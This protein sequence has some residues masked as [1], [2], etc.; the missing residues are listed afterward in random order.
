MESRLFINPVAI[1]SGL[2]PDLQ[3][4]IL[5]FLR[6]REAMGLTR[7]TKGSAGF[8]QSNALWAHFYRQD[9]GPLLCDLEPENQTVKPVLDTDVKIQYIAAHLFQEASQCK[10]N[11]MAQI[12]YRR[13]LV[14]LEPHRQKPWAQYYLA[15][16]QHYGCAMPADGKTGRQLL[17][18]CL[19]WNDYRAA[20]LVCDI[21]M[22][23]EVIYK[24]LGAVTC[25]QMDR[26]L[27]CLQAAYVKGL[28][29]A[30]LY[31]GHI[32]QHGEQFGLQEN[33]AEAEVWY[34]QALK[35][36]L[37]AAVGLLTDLKTD[38]SGFADP[39]EDAEFVYSYLLG[40]A[41]EYA[42]SPAIIAE[43]HYQA[44][45]Q[46][47]GIDLDE[48]DTHLSRANALG[49]F[50][51]KLLLGRL[52]REY[53]LI[54]Q[55]R[56]DEMEW[57][58]D[59][60]LLFQEGFEA[61]EPGFAAALFSAHQRVQAIQSPTPDPDTILDSLAMLA[62]NN[63]ADFLNT[64]CDHILDNRDW[65]DL[66]KN[67]RKAWWILLGAQY[68][69]NVAISLL[70]DM[71]KDA[72]CPTHFLCA[73]GVIKHFGILGRQEACDFGDNHF[74]RAQAQDKYALQNFLDTGKELGVVLPEVETLL[75]E[76]IKL[77]KDQTPAAAPRQP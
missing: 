24:N 72:S 39:V 75:R 5:S 51:A 54:E 44:A 30:A 8:M 9:F 29:A 40:L 53:A 23:K 46:L 1:L 4:Y 68:G 77:Y 18:R 59:A 7:A 25:A 42:D 15:Y 49:H 22:G 20:M 66:N 19:E 28:K 33:P 60:I 35:H 34:R 38:T 41:T 31:I 52:Y 11:D 2:P 70:I 58:Q 69:R 16:M 74:A 3:L 6:R 21:L 61:G 32:H 14:F 10:R 73:L 12:R 26:I 67:S 27:P 36:R 47:E 56:H 65:S 63:C 55:S 76:Q 48:Y 57:M 13:L 37:P 43:I 45:L 62:P 50:P 17:F 64:A 71:N